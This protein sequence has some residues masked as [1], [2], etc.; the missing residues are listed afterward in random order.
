M[1]T[2]ALD[3]EEPLERIEATLGSIQIQLE[4]IELKLGQVEKQVAG[5]GRWLHTLTVF[6]GFLCAV[7]VG[8]FA[9]VLYAVL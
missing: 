6:G 5:H 8:L 2:I 3:I 4:C 9:R 1:R 7:L